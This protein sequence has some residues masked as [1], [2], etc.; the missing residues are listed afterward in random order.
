LFISLGDIVLYRCNNSRFDN[1]TGPDA[2]LYL[3]IDDDLYIQG[4]VSGLKH[5]QGHDDGTVWAPRAGYQE[6]L[7]EF[8]YRLR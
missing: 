2:M 1:R 3:I 5:R 4:R 6:C 7:Y 8:E